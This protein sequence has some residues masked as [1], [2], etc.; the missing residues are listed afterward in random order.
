ML[1]VIWN[2]VLLTEHDNKSS[3]YTPVISIAQ[4]MLQVVC[5]ATLLSALAWIS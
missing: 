4:E 3:N 2:T 1:L 5:C